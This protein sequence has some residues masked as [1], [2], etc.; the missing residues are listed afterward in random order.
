M[1]EETTLTQ[2]LADSV[3]LEHSIF[4]RN[5]IAHLFIHHDK[6]VGMHAVPGLLIETE[7]IDEGIHIKLL[8]EEE[9]VIPQTPRPPRPQ[10]PPLQSAPASCWSAPIVAAP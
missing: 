7:S 6:V 2:H 4:E 8:L 10:R 9:T 5:D 1:M 3:G